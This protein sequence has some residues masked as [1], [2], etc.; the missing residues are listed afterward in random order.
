GRSLLE[1]VAPSSRSRVSERVAART[2]E[3]IE[4]EI[5]TR[6]GEERTIRVVAQNVDYRGRPARLAA[7]TD[8]AAERS[9]EDERARVQQRYRAL[10]ES[11]PV[12]VTLATIDGVYVEAND[13]YCRLTRRAHDEVVGHH[14]T[15]FTSPGRGGD[16]EVLDAILRGEQGPFNFESEIIDADGHATPV[17]VSVAVVRD[18]DEAPLYTVTMLES[19][20]EQR[21]LEAQI[22]QQQKMEA[23]GRLSSGVAHDF[24]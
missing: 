1:F 24:N 20:A 19:I 5:V 3:P 9:A 2:D 7:I 17:R 15:E 12:G 13:V 16:P 18:E 6:D 8:V 4:L 23:I 10:F 21:Q 22:R 14:F 11:V